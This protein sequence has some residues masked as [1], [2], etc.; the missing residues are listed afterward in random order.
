M[1]GRFFGSFFA[2]KKGLPYVTPRD[3]GVTRTSCYRKR[4][5]NAGLFMLADDPWERGDV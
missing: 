1:K 3:L 2:K 5:C 4:Q